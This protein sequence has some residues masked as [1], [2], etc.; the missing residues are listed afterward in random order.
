M[1]YSR[2]D[3]DITSSSLVVTASAELSGLWF[4][5]AFRTGNNIYY[6]WAW[7]DGTDPGNLNCSPSNRGCGLWRIGQPGYVVVAT[8]SVIAEVLWVRHDYLPFALSLPIPFHPPALA[9]L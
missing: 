1:Q 7:V 9:C 3:L 4:I 5:G 6:G 8:N 2:A